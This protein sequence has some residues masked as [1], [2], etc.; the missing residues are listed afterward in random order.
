MTGWSEHNCAICQGQR[1]CLPKQD[2]GV[3]PT[4][5]ELVCPDSTQKD[6]GDLYW[7]VYQLLRLP[8]RGCCEKATMECLHKDILD[9]LKECLRLKWPSAQ[10]E[11]EHQPVWPMPL[12]LI[13]ICSLMWLTTTHEEF[14]A[15]EAGFMQ[16]D[17]GHSEVCPLAAILEE[18]IE[19]MS[20]SISH[21]HSGSHQCSGSH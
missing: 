14:T 10:P 16:G 9:S 5:M 12:G 19:Q 20:H 1:E 8:R 2:L 3:E 15:N 7:D 13:L 17:T 4:A 11:G 6:I 21:H 18:K